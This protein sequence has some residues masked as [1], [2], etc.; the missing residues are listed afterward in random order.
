MLAPQGLAQSATVD[1]GARRI[2]LRV[3]PIYPPL[4][5]QMNVSGRVKIEAT[6]AADGHVVST[7]VVGGSPILVNASIDAVKRF[8]FEPGPRETEEM[9]EFQFDR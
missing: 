8:Q 3:T 1:G 5:K 4:A 2:R 9:I 6:V 7:R